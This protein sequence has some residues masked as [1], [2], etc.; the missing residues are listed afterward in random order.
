MNIHKISCLLL[1]ALF[2]I[3]GCAAG[4]D[5]GSA[6]P[7]TSAPV[8]AAEQPVNETQV[9]A[10]LDAAAKDMVAR[11]QRT[12]VP[13]RAKPRVRQ[14]GKTVI[15]TYIVIDSDSVSTSLRKGTGANTPYTALVN[16]S[17][18][19]MECTGSSRA[20][21]LADE[22][23]CRPIKTLHVREFIRFDGKRWIY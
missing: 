17:E 13:S 9:K 12:V 15:V 21:A 6:S 8:T 18:N 2:L 11:A 16:Y 22:A 10:S 20:R 3:G 1:G 23:S 14:S 5:A 19:L 7:E 4:G